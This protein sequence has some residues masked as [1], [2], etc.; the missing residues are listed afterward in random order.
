MEGPTPPSTPPPYL[1]DDAVVISREERRVVVDVG[2]IDVD[3][4][5][6]DSGWTA[7]ISRLHRKGIT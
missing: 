2:H 7:V 5:C 1:D 4:G 6:V 3:R